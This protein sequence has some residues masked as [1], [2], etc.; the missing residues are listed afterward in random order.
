MELL[1]CNF[2]RHISFDEERPIHTVVEGLKAKAAPNQPK[3]E[4]L[5]HRMILCASN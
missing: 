2:M 1:V 5:E 3:L 4:M